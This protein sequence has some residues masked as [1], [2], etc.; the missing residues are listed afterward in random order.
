MEF[1][2]LAQLWF[3]SCVGFGVEFFVLPLVLMVSFYCFGESVGFDVEF[4]V[5]ALILVVSFYWFG[6]SY[7]LGGVFFFFFMFLCTRDMSFL[8]VVSS[9]YDIIWYFVLSIYVLLERK[10]GYIYKFCYLKKKCAL[11]LRVI[12]IIELNKRYENNPME[13][14]EVSLIEWRGLFIDCIL[15]YLVI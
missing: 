2:V 5:L 4:F 13:R 12:T 1:E 3:C 8:L 7:R 15:C 9:I 6:G 14:L 11:L 10:L